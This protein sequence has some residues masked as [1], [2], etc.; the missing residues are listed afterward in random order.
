VIGAAI[1]LALTCAVSA[2]AAFRPDGGPDPIVAEWSQWP[3]EVSCGY[4]S[5][6]PVSV[7]GG[8]A[9]AEHGSLP[10]ERAL[11]RSLARRT[12]PWVRQHNWRLAAETHRLAEFITGRLG[13]R[14]GYDEET[15]LETMSFQRTRR[16]WKWTGYGG[17]CTL[18]S[19]R[20]NRTAITWSLAEDQLLTPSTRRVRVDLGA[21][22][23]DS[24]RSQNDRLQK[25][26][27]R[28]QNGKLLMSLW[29]RPLPPGGY[30]CQGL[31]ETPV[32]IKLPEPLGERELMDGGA[33]PPRR[34][35]G[36]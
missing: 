13:Y 2:S 34:V 36:G 4:L 35:I 33:Y 10:A 28:E 24:G 3:H 20:Q 7:F 12:I 27:F 32:T 30:T 29:L 1:C 6:D 11:R 14:G 5:F 21:G 22:E 18:S 17:G 19:I 25:P 15:E 9:D 8:P 16:G 31:I 26:E 23:C